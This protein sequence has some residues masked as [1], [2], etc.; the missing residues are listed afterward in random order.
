M[1]SP[2]STSAQRVLILIATYN[3]RENL[4]LL[5]DRV[6][7][8]VD[9][10]VLVIDDG[11]PDGTGEIADAIARTEPRLRVVHREGKQGVASAHVLGF[12]HALDHGYDVM[13][14][15]DADFSHPPEDLPRLL[16]ASRR[17]DVVLGSRAV[18]GGAIL[19]RSPMRNL[20]TR[21]GCAYARTVL[22]LSV[23]DCTGGFRCSNR[24]A[25][26]T[27][28]W[29]RV[30]SQ[31]YGFQLE[32]NRAWTLAGARFEEI[33]IRFP[34]RRA[35][36]SKMTSAILVESLLVVLRLRFHLVP[37]ALKSRV[38]LATSAH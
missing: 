23:R 35:G 27:I 31:G 36:K 20:L 14:E 6:F 33:P 18:P 11:S 19:G 7:Q 17:A 30:T 8:H 4:P 28:D 32:L 15:M 5:L 26:E 16:E 1:E 3:E 9:G 37:S 12:R 38:S 13:V 21:L 24:A 25:L 2:L 29:S 34:D 22:S 10:D